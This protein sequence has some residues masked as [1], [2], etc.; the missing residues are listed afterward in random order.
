MNLLYVY[1]QNERDIYSH[2][3]RLKN[4]V[5]KRIKKGLNVR[6]DYLANCATMKQISFLALKYAAKFGE[7][8]SKIERKEAEKMTAK[9]IMKWASE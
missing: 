4:Q 6:E 2:V 8:Y 5:Q 1:I 9:Y 7:H 3:E